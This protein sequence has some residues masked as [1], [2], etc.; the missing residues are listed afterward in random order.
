MGPPLDGIPL[1]IA[2]L[3]RVVLILYS[4]PTGIAKGMHL[5]LT[6]TVMLFTHARFLLE[7]ANQFILQ[8]ALFG[9]LDLG[10]QNLILETRL[11][12]IIRWPQ[13]CRRSDVAFD[14]RWLVVMARRH[15]T[16]ADATTMTAGL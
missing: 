11:H 5:W 12:L 4:Q 10:M 15:R 14:C 7:G 2:I 6:L 13:L 16:V 1:H 3:F 9:E 8:A